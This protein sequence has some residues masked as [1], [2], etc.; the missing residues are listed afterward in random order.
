[1]VMLTFLDS[2]ITLELY[3][4]S[5]SLIK[6]QKY[7]GVGIVYFCYSIEVIF[8]FYDGEELHVIFCLSNETS[9]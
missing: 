8:Y 7:V 5:F 3:C 4:K 2:A 6:I 1:M 9:P